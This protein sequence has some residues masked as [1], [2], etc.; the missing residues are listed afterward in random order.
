MAVIKV[1]DPNSGEVKQF[2]IEGDTPTD[3]EKQ[4]I[5]SVISQSE[6]SLPTLGQ[7]KGLGLIEAEV[8]P[9]LV[10][11]KVPHVGFNKVEMIN[12]N[13]ILVGLSNEEFYFMHSFEVVNSSD[14]TSYTQYEDHKFV[15]T[16][17]KG[18]IY[19]VQFHPEKSRAAG[20]QILRNF[21]N[22]EKE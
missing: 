13:D 5:L 12:T 1:R 8:R 20:I 9:I 22:L 18:N 19:G 10:D 15:S 7:I 11:A 16:I 6:P 14:I 17:Q 3:Q 4:Q 21:I 2:R